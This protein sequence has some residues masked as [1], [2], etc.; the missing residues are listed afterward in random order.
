ME[1][2]VAPFVP[3]IQMQSEEDVA[4]DLIGFFSLQVENPGAIRGGFRWHFCPK[5]S[6]RGVGP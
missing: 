5:N 2:V 6:P 4:L 1:P 3:F